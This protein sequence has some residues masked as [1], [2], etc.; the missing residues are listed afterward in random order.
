MFG[1][2]KK[3]N[4]TKELLALT[5]LQ[6][7]VLRE[8]KTLISHLANKTAGDK[9]PQVTDPILIMDK[10]CG[11][12]YNQKQGVCVVISKQKDSYYAGI[13]DIG[14]LPENYGIAYPIRIQKDLIYFTLEGYAIF[15][16]YKENVNQIILCGKLSLLRKIA[17]ACF[18]PDIVFDFVP[19]KSH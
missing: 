13:G 1:L 3:K 8:F 18:Y 7:E 12:W 2:F 4:Y 16:E 19:F 9:K 10:I 17:D 14:S 11:E 15:I 5:I 6:N